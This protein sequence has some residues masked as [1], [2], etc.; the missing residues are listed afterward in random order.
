MIASDEGTVER[1]MVR[2]LYGLVSTRQNAKKG[3]NI[4]HLFTE[5]Q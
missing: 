4:M 1:Y 2:K 5:K 3:C